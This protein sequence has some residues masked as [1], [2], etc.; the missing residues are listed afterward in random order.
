MSRCFRDT[1]TTNKFLLGLD[2]GTYDGVVCVASTSNHYDAQ[3]M[4]EIA[5]SRKMGELL[6]VAEFDDV[7]DPALP[8]A[9]DEA[10]AQDIYGFLRAHD[11]EDA[12]FQF[13]CDGSVSRSAGMLC[14]WRRLCGEDDLALWANAANFSPNV[15]VYARLLA[16]GGTRLTKAQMREREL[17]KKM[18]FTRMMSGRGVHAMHLY[19]RPWRQ[20]TSGDKSCELR[21]LD[22]KRRDIM[23]GDLVAFSLRGAPDSIVAADV[24]ECRMSTSF[25]DLVC[26]EDVMASSG[27]G[28]AQ[29]VLAALEKIYGENEYPAVAFF[30]D[31]S[32]WERG[33]ANLA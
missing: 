33:S 4:R 24:L 25:E 17:L 16:A 7:A 15:L 9:M 2:E 18:A 8:G 32:E 13:V 3:A 1:V 14:A 6:Y 28:S 10:L 12:E 27:F 20:I 11:D 21:R 23:A 29:E 5:T 26:D 31:V 19:E 30:L 22:Y